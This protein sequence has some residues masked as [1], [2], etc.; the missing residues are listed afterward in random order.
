MEDNP[1]KIE[2]SIIDQ[3]SL[4]YLLGE[5]PIDEGQTRPLGGLNPYSEHFTKIGQHFLQLF[6]D[7]GRLTKR[8]KVLEAGCGTGRIAKALEGFLDGGKYQGFDC[9][10][11]FTDHC[12]STYKKS[13]KFQRFS[14]SFRAT[15]IPPLFNLY[16]KK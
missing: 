8:S 13:F 16:F 6:I 2:T 7:H 11:R 14:C 9:N 3:P 15:I 5:I 1:K 10:K 12:K 4:P